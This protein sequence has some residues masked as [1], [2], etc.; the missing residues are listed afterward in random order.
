MEWM[1]RLRIGFTSWSTVPLLFS[2]CLALIDALDRD[3]QQPFCYASFLPRLLA[4]VLGSVVIVVAVV[5]FSYSIRQFQTAGTPVPGNKPTT[6]LVRTDPYCFSR[7]P[8]YVA[9]SVFQLGIASWVNS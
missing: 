1:A 5:V 3:A 8:I 2:S 9:F 6:V 7:N 4:A